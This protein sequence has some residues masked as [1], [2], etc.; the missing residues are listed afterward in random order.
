MHKE[1]YYILQKAYRLAEEEKELSFE[2][3]FQTGK[4]ALILNK[5]DKAMKSFLKCISIKRN[6]FAI[7]FK[8]RRKKIIFEY[9]YNT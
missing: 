2:L 6:E 1:A 5:N 9:S 4:T 7:D 8:R 3:V